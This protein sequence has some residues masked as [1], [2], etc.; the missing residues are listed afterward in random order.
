MKR[1]LISR[2]L[3]SWFIVVAA[4]AFAASAFG[5]G[6]KFQ[7]LY[8]FGG[9]SDGYNPRGNLIADK[10]GNLYGTTE[11][12]GASFY[13]TVF[14]LS[15]PATAGGDWTHTILYT[16]N[17][18]GD[19]ARPTD[20]LIIDGKGNLYGTTSD[21]AG[22]YGEVF[23]LS[24]PASQ[25]A[26]WT[27]TV[28]Y[29]FQG[30]QDGA[31]P[32]G[33]VVLGENG[34]LFGT[35]DYTVFELSPPSESGGVWSFFRLHRFTSQTS[36]GFS[37]QA[38]LVRD[39]HGNLYGT[40]LWGGYLT[41][42]SCGSLGCGTVFELSPPTGS[43]GWTEQVIHTFGASSTDGFDPESGLA[44]DANGNLYGTTYSGG[45]LGG[46]IAF[47]LSPPVTPGG[48]WTETDIH[49]FSYGSTDGAA[50]VAT[51]VLDKAGNLY[52]T[53]L[54]GGNG[55]FF[56]TVEYGC[57][58]VYELAPPAGGV[59]SWNETVLEYFQRGV[60][61]AHQSTA[62]VLLGEHGQIYGTTVY[63]GTYACYEGNGC[64]TVFRIKP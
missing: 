57:G 21:D 1:T 8:R 51:V 53:T 28:L 37:A 48:T 63:G 54:F 61:T 45:T 64:G 25:G 19:G 49:D 13:G 32:R 60:G 46:G 24:P 58:I 22:G 10:A 2:A 29:H 31:Y 12:G 39:K 23:Q 47:Q 17:N 44:L 6:P 35:T 30:K 27:E 7:V 62:G 9:T 43:Q 56:N 15:P 5:S 41:N 11:Y 33:G 4:L 26:P 36:D 16:F 38:G 50:P 40:T 3:T 20:G 34:N 59:G 55:C 18:T 52:G 42:P 14:E